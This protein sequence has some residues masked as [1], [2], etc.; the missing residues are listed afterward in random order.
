LQRRPEQLETAMLIDDAL[1]GWPRGATREA[2][3]WLATVPVKPIAA[4]GMPA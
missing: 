1:Y 3:D 4:R 2:R